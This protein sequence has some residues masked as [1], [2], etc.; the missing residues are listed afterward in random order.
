[1][2]SP[3]RCARSS[4]RPRPSLPA[5]QPPALTA[6][7]DAEHRVQLVHKLLRSLD[8][9]LRFYPADGSCDE[10]PGY[11]GHAGGSLLDCLDLLHSASAG[12]LD[13]YAEPLV[14]EIGRFIYRAYI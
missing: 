1:M 6:E 11:W 8:S 7:P 13:V 3:A 2:V 5:P 10:G 9:F 4:P 12:K 14:Q